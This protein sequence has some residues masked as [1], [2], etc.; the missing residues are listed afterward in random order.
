MNLTSTGRSKGKWVLIIPGKGIRK[1]DLRLVSPD[2]HYDFAL[3]PDGDVISGNQREIHPLR[4][5]PLKNETLPPTKLDNVVKDIRD[6]VGQNFGRVQGKQLQ[7][8]IRGLRRKIGVPI[9]MKGKEYHQL[10]KRAGVSR[11]IS[12]GR[13]FYAVSV[14]DKDK[15]AE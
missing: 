7:D 11:K 8:A 1:Q 10:L 6:F 5:L 12:H 15:S 9:P 13:I 3:A 4:Q 2:G 14:P